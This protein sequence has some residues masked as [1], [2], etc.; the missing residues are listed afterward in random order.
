MIIKPLDVKFFQHHQQHQR[1]AWM[2]DLYPKDGGWVPIDTV[3]NWQ[4]FDKVKRSGPD[5]DNSMAVGLLRTVRE[6]LITTH[7]H[8]RLRT[9]A[10]Y[11]NSSTLAQYMLNYS[12]EDGRLIL[13]KRWARNLMRRIT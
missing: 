10:R 7:R 12:Q 2:G 4:G 9:V 3:I 13:Y 1:K 8:R 5:M 6:N 11:N